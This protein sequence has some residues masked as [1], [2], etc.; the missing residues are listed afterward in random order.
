MHVVVAPDKFKGSLT[1]AEVAARVAA[2]HRR[3][4]AGVPRCARSRWPTAATAPSTPPW[5]P[6]STPDRGACQRAP[7]RAGGHARSR[8]A[9]AI[10]VVEMADVSG[11]RRAAPATALGARCAAST[12]G[13]GELI[14]AALDAGCRRIVLGIGGSAS[15]DGGA[16]MLAALG[17]R[18]LDAD[19]ARAAPRRRRAAR[20]WPPARSD[21]LRPAAGRHRARAGLRRGQPAARARTAPPRSSAR[22]RAPTPTTSQ[23]L[24]AALAHWAELLAET[25]G[26]PAATARP[27]RGR[28]RRRCR[29]RGAAVLGADPAPGSSWCSTWSGS[30]DALRRRRP[31]DHRRGQLDEQTLYGKAPAGVAAAAR[32]AGVPVVAV[33]GRLR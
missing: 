30:R 22:R 25:A 12:V 19:G 29:L 33:S 31:G 9:T 20:R 3:G 8:C 24:D 15:T 13:T 2:G 6:A 10:A 7:R 27:A 16:G 4:R 17:A 18:L 32:A 23:L 14:A 11:L 26:A 21:R 5:P 28:R 1:A